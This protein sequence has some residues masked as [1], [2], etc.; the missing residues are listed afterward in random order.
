MND[1]SDLEQ[2]LRRLRPAQP[3]ADLI[4]RI[5]RAL[6]EAPAPA[7]AG[8]VR[9]KRQFHFSWLSLGVGVAAAT[10]LVIFA[11]LRLEQPMP[12]QTVASNTSP[13]LLSPASTAQLV[14]VGLTQVV[15]HTRDEG[16]HFPGNSNQ[17]VRRVRS[18]QR[19]VLQ[20][21]NPKTGASLKISYP[22]EEV[23]LVPVHGQ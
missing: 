10:A 9:P 7:T 2:Q 8:I 13:K 20:W 14:P 5:E 6:S 15:Y 17:P 12:K 4:A 3:S 22:V 1:F 18:Q 16:L 23:S 19:E 11:L 21:R